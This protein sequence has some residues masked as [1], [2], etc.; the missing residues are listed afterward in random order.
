MIS[1]VIKLDYTDIPQFSDKDIKYQTED[2]AYQDFY[3][4]PVKIEAFEQV[5]KERERFDI[6]RELLVNT[7]ISQYDF[8]DIDE[9]LK[10]TIHSL[11]DN[12][13]FTI[14]T[15]HQPVLL[16]GPLYVVYKILSTIHLCKTLKESYPKYNFVPVF[17][18]GGEDHDLE[19]VSTVHLFNNDITWNTGQSGAVGRMSLDDLQNAIDQATELF[20]NSPFADELRQIIRTS[21]ESSNS[22]G[23]FNSNLLKCLFSDLGLLVLNMDDK[24]LKN[25]FL[26]LAL[27]EIQEKISNTEVSKTQNQLA[28][29][30][31]GVQ[32]YVREINLFILGDGSRERLVE[33]GD[34][35]SYGDKSMS[36][37][38][39]KEFIK[40]Y[41][42]RISPNVVMRPIYQ[43]VILPNL[44][45]V[46]GGGE[47]A[48]WLERKSQ[49]QAFGI[50]YPMLI[51]RNSAL[52]VSK[53]LQKNITKVGLQ[54]QNFFQHIHDLIKH[55]LD[56]NTNEDFNLNEELAE[57]EKFFQRLALK[58]KSID[59]SL[60]KYTLAEGAKQVKAIK[61]IE[62]KMTKAAKS[63]NEIQ[64]KKI[65]NIKSKL[66]P[67]DGLQERYDS[68]IGY[69]LKYGRD[70]F[71]GLQ[72]HL[73]PLDKTF[74][75]IEE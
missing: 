26:P 46:G 2:P 57:Q 8:N 4:Y 51:R 55:F 28:E 36:K 13:T 74:L 23:E 27:K 14:T 32:A 30:G 53:G 47:I 9:T 5:I 56:K 38:E 67:N 6:D 1:K 72:E 22:Y 34:K 29:K 60:E 16:L 20:G 43:E 73:N 42:D 25:R 62:S 10:A 66:F 15:A 18:S 17:V 63:K 35:Y 39:L 61:V 52:I 44:A 49:F 69:Y 48:Y 50:P 54:S 19:E 31:I 59:P 11:K 64:L 68:F 65:E 75:V 21:Y 71:K 41:P 70:W 12:N 3:K 45:Y 58:A 24:N 40:K 7:I 37:N 33:E